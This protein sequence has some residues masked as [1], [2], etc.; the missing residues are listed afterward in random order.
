MPLIAPCLKKMSFKSLN[1]SQKKMY[2]FSIYTI[3]TL[4]AQGIVREDFDS[5]HV[6]LSLI[7]SFDYDAY[8]NE[9]KSH[10]K[11][12]RATKA[13]KHSSEVLRDSSDD[14]VVALANEFYENGITTPICFN[15]NQALNDAAAADVA[16]SCENGTSE[17]VLHNNNNNNNSVLLG[18]TDEAPAAAAEKNKRKYN[19]KPKNDSAVASVA[20]VA[21]V[22][23]M[24]DMLSASLD[25]L[26]IQL[27]DVSN[28]IDSDGGA[29]AVVEAAAAAEKPKRKYN[30]KPKDA[31]KTDV[32][33]D[34]EVVPTES[35][36][37]G[38]VSTDAAEVV[39]AV[40]E[41]PKRKNNKKTKTTE[42]VVSP[43]VVSAEAE[44]EVSAEV[45]AE[46]A[47][48]PKR[49]NNKKTKTAAEVV[50]TE[51]VSATEVVAEVTE[52][53]SEKPKRKY[54]KKTA[55]QYIDETVPEITAKIVSA[56]I[57]GAAAA[58]ADADGYTTETEEEQ[59]VRS[60]SPILM[61]SCEEEPYEDD[62][63]TVCDDEDDEDDEDEYE[64]IVTKKVNIRGQDYLIGTNNKVYDYVSQKTVGKYR[65]DDVV[66]F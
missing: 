58:P 16:P 63:A 60:G 51:V 14:V 37:S 53:V 50:A 18:A 48:K 27:H 17:S 64:D 21:A 33:V 5:F 3:N 20:S 45:S 41:K 36:S 42:V 22:D 47:E 13:L 24:I 38:V 7:E 34:M 56:A 54:T 46:V 49:K 30:R 52:E 32:V 62:T 25:Q 43:E 31:V 8:L 19:R 10:F 9:Y 23:N 66:L 28:D 2:L 55:V 39:A 26:S 65:S 11:K 1:A 44:A 12:P 29:A 4:K 57:Q 61:N 40:T 6:D 59:I 15:M 35:I